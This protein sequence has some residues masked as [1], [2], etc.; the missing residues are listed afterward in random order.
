MTGIESRCVSWWEVHEFALP[1]LDEAGSWPMAGSLAW[2]NLPEADPAKLAA[3]LDGG[4]HWALR[5]ETA[6]T[7]LAQAS[8]DISASADWPAIARD[9][10]RRQDAHIRRRTA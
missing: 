3:V 9:I 2:R 8:R 7:A 1:F 10:R 4:R 5:V 6:Q